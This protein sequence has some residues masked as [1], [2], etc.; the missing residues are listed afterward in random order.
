MTD[1][2][3]EQFGEQE[4]GE[5][6]Q[7]TPGDISLT[8]EELAALC[9]ETVCPECPEKADFDDQRLRLLADMDNLRKRLE[10]EKEAF[11]R[12]AGE[13]VLADLLPVLDNLDLA[14]A[15]APDGACKDFVIGVDMTRKVFLDVLSR[16]G[17]RAVGAEGEPFSP[18]VHEAVGREERAD[19]DKDRVCKL[20][21]K[22]YI[23]KD[24]LLRPAAV[25]VS[26]PPGGAGEGEE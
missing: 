2:H 22:G 7:A 9:R 8:R 15:H 14:L 23:L 18:E 20:L 4:S 6:P 26:C 5:S 19:M 25:M 13:G 24:R 17:L 16:H 12:Y 10:R 21:K 11:C 1:E 3:Q